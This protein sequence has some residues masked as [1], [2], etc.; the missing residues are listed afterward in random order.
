MGDSRAVLGVKNFDK[1]TCTAK[2]MSV[3]HTPDKP[4][5]HNRIKKAGGFITSDNRVLGHLNL[6]RAIGDLGYKSDQTI[7]PNEQMILN[8]ADVTIE[9]L[10]DAAFLIIACDG[11]WDCVSSQEAVDFV[12][13]L[14]KKKKEVTRIS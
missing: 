11:V 14:L 5:E 1:K 9:K 8:Q 7:K 13:K 4:E 10:A 2:D 6:S 12:E 3:D